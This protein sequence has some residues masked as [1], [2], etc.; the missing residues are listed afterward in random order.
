MAKFEVIN[1]LTLRIIFDN[2]ERV[3]TKAGA[4]IGFQGSLK[5]D[6]EAAF[7]SIIGAVNEEIQ[8]AEQVTKPVKE[9][10]KRI[11]LAVYPSAYS[12]LQKIA[13]V[14]RQSVSD[15]ISQL[16]AEYVANNSDKLEEYE[17]LK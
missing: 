10:K 9:T 17:K 5:F 12:D 3:H 7:K 4:M 1:E 15:I 6:K 8:K 11:S 16:I 2:T 14:N 13:Y